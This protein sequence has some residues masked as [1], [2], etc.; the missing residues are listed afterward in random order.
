MGNEKSIEDIL[1]SAA[2]IYESKFSSINSLEEA[3]SEIA[4]LKKAFG[5]GMFNKIFYVNSRGGGIRSYVNKKNIGTI[6]NNMSDDAKLGKFPM[7]YSIGMNGVI[8]GEKVD[9]K[10]FEKLP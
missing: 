3:T 5:K 8:E 4:F 9:T 7:E 6:L 10:I 2:P 1:K